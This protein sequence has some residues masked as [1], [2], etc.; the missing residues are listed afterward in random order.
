MISVRV[1][2]RER[3]AELVGEIGREKK[4]ECEQS[5]MF[6]KQAYYGPLIF[7]TLRW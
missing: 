2:K 7:N 6:H 3:D 1:R 4:G 5:Q